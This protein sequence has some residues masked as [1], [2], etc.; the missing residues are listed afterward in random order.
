MTVGCGH[1]W[2]IDIMNIHDVY[3]VNARLTHVASIRGHDRRSCIHVYQHGSAASKPRQGLW[4]PQVEIWEY[5]E[6]GACHIIVLWLLCFNVMSSIIVNEK[7][8]YTHW[9]CENVV[10]SHAYCVPRRNND[11][12]PLRRP[13]KFPEIYLPSLCGAGRGRPRRWAGCGSIVYLR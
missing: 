13:S 6:A 12:Q 4:L 10:H 5:W 11:Y 2:I 7:F 8:A 9:A 3:G 1:V